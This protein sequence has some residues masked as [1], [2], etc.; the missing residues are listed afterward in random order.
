[1]K[2]HPLPTISPLPARAAGAIVASLALAA[3]V[4]TTVL[5]TNQED[6]ASIAVPASTGPGMA[7]ER[8]GAIAASQMSGPSTT[9]DAGNASASPHTVYLVE[10][11]AAADELG[12]VLA[13]REVPYVANGSATGTYEIVH[14][15]SP[16]MKGEL[17]AGFDH[18]LR[19][20]AE[21]GLG[22]FRIVDF[23]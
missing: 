4:V 2:A 11:E 12:Q 21:S 22:P 19:V 5:V 9:L 14:V 16:A 1:M 17:L 7:I 13:S 6:G 18:A 23:Q 3:I 20:R 10:T 8:D 15:Q